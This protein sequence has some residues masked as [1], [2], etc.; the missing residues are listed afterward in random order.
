MA[1]ISAL[2]PEP[3]AFATPRR[4]AVLVVEDRD[5]VRDGMAQ[6]LELHGFLVAD[7]R[8]ADEALQ[9]LESDPRG[10]ALILLDLLLP[11]GPSGHDFRMQQLADPVLAA[12]PTVVVTVADVDPQERAALRT[13]GWLEKPFRCADLL[14]LVKRYVVSEGSAL[15]AEP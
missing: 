14:E 10:F 8:D 6:L 3:A 13:E 5:D 15:Q 4:G 7:A 1:E 2:P 9:Q 11:G 12:I